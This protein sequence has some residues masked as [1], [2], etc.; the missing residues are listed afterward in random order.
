M[1]SPSNNNTII[2]II[3]FLFFSVPGIF[4]TV[5]L[6]ICEI[7]TLHFIHSRIHGAVG[8][9]NTAQLGV[10]CLAQGHFVTQTGQVRV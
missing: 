1:F 4:V 9:I 3:I 2:I 10:K 8:A 5:H 6:H 7:R